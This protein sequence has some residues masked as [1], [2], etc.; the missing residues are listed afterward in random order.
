MTNTKAF[1]Y[2][3]IENL[4]LFL[5]GGFIYVSIELIGRG[6][7]HVSMFIVGGACFL[8]IGLLNEFY[9]WEFLFEAQIGIGT[10]VITCLEFISGYIVNIKLGLNIW[11]YSEFPLNLYGQICLHH[12]LFFWVPLSAVAIV[13][14][15]LLRFVI[16]KEQFPKYYFIAQKLNKKK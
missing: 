14:D 10:F 3:C 4:I 1:I 6:F 8:I 12:S 7:S 15:D 13:L 11:D 9:P 2:K 5:I 16:W